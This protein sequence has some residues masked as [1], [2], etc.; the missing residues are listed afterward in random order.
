MRKAWTKGQIEEFERLK[1]AL[2]RYQ[3][4]PNQTFENYLEEINK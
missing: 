2:P 3:E 1:D 4:I